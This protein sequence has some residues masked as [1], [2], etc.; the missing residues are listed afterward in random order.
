ME[1]SANSRLEKMAAQ[2]KRVKKELDETSRELKRVSASVAKMQSQQVLLLAV[3]CFVVAFRGGDCAVQV[4]GR[5]EGRA[6]RLKQ[7]R[8]NWRWVRFVGAAF[9]PLVWLVIGEPELEGAGKGLLKWATSLLA[10]AGGREP[11][12]LPSPVNVR[13]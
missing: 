2:E 11:S 10:W 4:N 13:R 12:A 5:V 6:P 3:I 8:K 1:S 9:L 7:Q